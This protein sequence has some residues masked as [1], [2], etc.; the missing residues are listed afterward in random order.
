MKFISSIVSL[1]K[2]LKNRP[3]AP[4]QNESV[5]LPSFF[6]NRKIDHV[7]NID[8]DESNLKNYKIFNLGFEW[9]FYF[10]NDISIESDTYI[11]E[12]YF[13]LRKQFND[14]G[15]YFFYLPILLENIN[16]DILPAIR[17]TFPSFSD[18]LNYSIIEELNNS[19][20]DYN[21]ILKEFILFISYKGTIS[22]G[23]ISENSGYSIV[24]QKENETIKDF[25]DGYIENLSFYNKNTSSDRFYSIENKA[26][27]EKSDT[28]KESLENLR[29]INEQIEFLRENGQLAILAPKIYEFLKK[30]L[31]GIIY[32]KTFPMVI[33]EDF[34]IIIPE[35]NNLEIKL[36]HLTK[37][38]YL[39]FLS[40]A[41]P[42]DL[43]DLHLYKNQ[44][45]SIYKQVSNQNSYDKIKETVEELIKVDNEAIYVH[46][47]RIKKAFMI[48]FSELIASKYYITGFKSQSKKILFERKDVTFNYKINDMQGC[49]SKD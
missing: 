35:C 15:R 47:S 18:D 12:N 49:N 25:L 33:T 7:R 43:K 5:G 41:N 13:E 28:E 4:V 10:E 20:Y 46:F 45:L 1:I 38:I 42:I 19:N 3:D 30:N 21:L 24:E 11:R 14:K 27:N 36:S 29:K 26:N 17:S 9:V 37:S 6:D 39:L 48:H 8:I 2:P 32:N 22:K 34:K 16:T 31:D 40:N 23:C 44:L